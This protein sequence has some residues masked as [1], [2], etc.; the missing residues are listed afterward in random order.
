MRISS[1]EIGSFRGFSQK[2]RF[3]F[4]QTQILVLYGPNGHGK[5]SFFDAIEW[6]LTGEICRYNSPSDEKNKTRFIG[7][8]LSSQ[9]PRVQIEIIASNGDVLVLTRTGIVV[10]DNRSDYGKSSLV[11]VVN[12]LRSEGKAAEG[13]LRKCLI[14]EAWLDKIDLNR[15]LNLSHF[16]GQE[17]ISFILRG[18]RDS[19]RYDSMSL[20]FG[21]EHFY[22][23]K[24]SFL[25]VKKTLESD[26]KDKELIINQR[27]QHRRNFQEQVENIRKKL[28][29]NDEEGKDVILEVLH[30]LVFKLGI[31]IP[32]KMEL[33]GYRSILENKR[34]ELQRKRYN[35]NDYE[36][37]Y[38]ILI[39]TVP[40]WKNANK[41]IQENK[42]KLNNY[43][44]L[45]DIETKLKN[46]QWLKEKYAEFKNTEEQITK[47][48]LQIQELNNTIIIK[49]SV[50]NELYKLLHNLNE[51]MGQHHLEDYVPKIFELLTLC[52]F[53][54]RGIKE[55]IHKNLLDLLETHKLLIID[56]EKYQIALSSY[57]SWEDIYNNIKTTDFSHKE[58][59]KNVK[60]FISEDRKLS[61]CPV[62]GTEG[63]SA[64]H[65]LKYIDEQ[66]QLIHP[67][68]NTT[69][70]C[71]EDARKQFKELEIL[72]AKNKN[73]IKNG[74][75]NLQNLTDKVQQLFEDENRSTAQ[76][77]EQMGILRERR[78]Q[79]EKLSTEFRE[80]SELLNI[81]LNGNVLSEFT[82]A[83]NMLLLCT[84]DLGIDGTPNRVEITKAVK[85]ASDNIQKADNIQL[86]F[87]DRFID[88]TG[89]QPN[90]LQDVEL[91][92]HKE[93][94]KLQQDI[95]LLNSHEQ[96]T[97]KGVA[98]IARE[99]DLETLSNLTVQINQIEQTI[100]QLQFEKDNL[101]NDLETVKEVIDKIPEAV[102]KLNEQVVDELLETIQSIFFRINSHP[103]YRY[104]EFDTNQRY[105]VNRLILSVLT[106]GNEIDSMDKANP[107]FI[108][109]SAQI[110]AIALSFFLSM[111]LKQ[112]W[113]RLKFICMDDPVQSM[114]DF[115]VLAFVDLIRLIT[116]NDR[117][118]NKQVIISTHDSTFFELIKRK[119]RFL[120]LGIIK[121]E[122]YGVQ[123][124][125]FQMDNFN[126]QSLVEFVHPREN[127]ILPEDFLSIEKELIS[128]KF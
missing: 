66:E 43:E 81:K 23:F 99:L 119:F 87:N 106:G 33:Q 110:N 74:L 19:E 54:D 111:A 11:V 51:L 37:R 47:I 3:D 18:M 2:R 12:G 52:E 88:L 100:Q 53:L 46:I 90:S 41:A 39:S 31:D 29:D 27:M 94:E 121:F 69:L 117:G 65:I 77:S 128:F 85:L 26:I 67:E 6:V 107:S 126:A 60:T 125:S 124:P 62:C 17:R 103:L 1:L 122:G 72:V 44:V 68:L 34:E 95:S 97:L 8:R 70:S 118:M 14:H 86:Q 109:S 58:F 36:S 127:K 5:T 22:K 35:L 55:E 45:L 101:E 78:D 25:D 21:T 16:L 116:E 108:F 61:R 115:N 40:E 49:E 76:I 71:L 48:A 123:G 73:K 4:E 28:I 113:T 89:T 105:K 112:H 120:K 15:G 57:Q 114:D 92:L 59:L 42:E 7:N 13:T 80:R 79:I 38:R 82:K 30:P 75:Q 93:E 50:I 10:A 64:G 32:Q 56:S 102:D 24:Q 91:L 96:L 83:E 63:M 84:K 104:L 98:I 9:P 20:I